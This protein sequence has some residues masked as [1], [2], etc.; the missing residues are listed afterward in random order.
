MPILEINAAMATL[1]GSSQYTI[2]TV[3]LTGYAL[4]A[5]AIFGGGGY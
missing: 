1:H 2:G 4:I 3:D 5:A